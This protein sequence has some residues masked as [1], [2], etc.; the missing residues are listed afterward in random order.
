MTNNDL[1]QIRIFVHVAR[2]KSFTKAALVMQIEKSTVSAKISQLETRLNIRL[3]QRTTRSVSLTEPGTQYLSYCEQALDI[4]AMGDEYIAG[5]QKVPA[6]L[7]RVSAPHNL[8]DA[9]LPSV[10]APFLKKYPKVR[11]EFVQSNGEADLIKNNYDIA[12]RSSAATLKDS[13]LIYRQIYQSD[14]TLV[15][16]KLHVEEYGLATNPIQL[17]EQPSI[18]V[19][20]ESSHTQHGDSFNW[21]NQKVVLSH[22]FA[23]NNMNS[24]KLAV[25]DDLG[26]AILPRRMV[27]RELAR[28]TLVEISKDIDFKPTRLYLVY[29]SRTGQTAILKVFIDAII[30]WANETLVGLP[31]QVVARD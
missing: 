7:L 26:F 21:H 23:V 13:S 8:V 3:L 22:R 25:L 30:G 4:L 11:L 15:A 24:V 1:N 28:G 2:Y 19:I 10:I 16:S 18:G 14:W 12:F 29:P 6:G 20:R 17:S 27:R 9:L 31:A 5:L